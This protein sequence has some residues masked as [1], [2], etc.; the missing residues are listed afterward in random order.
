MSSHEQHSTGQRLFRAFDRVRKANWRRGA[1]AS[2]RPSEMKLLFYVKRG[3]SFNALGMTISEISSGLEVTSPTVTQLINSLETQ[4]LVERRMD[5]DDRRVVRVTLTDE[6]H[7]SIAKAR[8]AL[9]GRFDDLIEHLG[10]QRS[11]QLAD[12]LE[13][14]AEFMSNRPDK[15]E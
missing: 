8:E 13:E 14:V 4:G 12:L 2:H 10:T 9:F 6:G 1:E 7:A 15:A 11:E 5:Q 3:L